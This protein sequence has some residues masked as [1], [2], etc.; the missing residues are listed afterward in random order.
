MA[1]LTIFATPK[2]FTD[3]HIDLIQQNAIGSW[4]HLGED[5]EVVLV[6]EEEG[7]SAVVE[8]YQ[9]AHQPRVSRNEWG[10]PLVDSIFIQARKTSQ[11]DLLVYL[12][13]DI[14]LTPDFVT[15]VQEIKRIEERFLIVGRRWDLRVEEEI[16]FRGKWVH[17]L[18]QKICNQGKLHDH[19]ALDYFVFPREI[20]T[21]IPP[22]AIGRAGWDNWMVY[23]ALKQGWTVIDV[24]PSVIVIHQDH[25]YDHLPEGKPHY[26][27]DES[28]HNVI[29]GGG[30]TKVYDL[31][32]VNWEFRDGRIRK[33]QLTIPRMLRKMERRVMPQRKEGWRWRLTRKLR[34]LRRK[35][36]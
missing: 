24:T 4:L 16:D 8:K 34:Q 6:G 31:L 11:N 19:T 27:L 21:D 32:D 12:N 29:L 30:F 9:I 7:Y 35:V 13:A 23:H 17:E 33:V 5:V 20:F 36:S 18:E 1:Q 15:A 22:F 3:P 2:P 14:I 28:S 25:D 10:T 26:D